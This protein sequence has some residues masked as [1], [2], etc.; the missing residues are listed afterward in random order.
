MFKVTKYPQGAFSWADCSS[1]NANEV[2]K[3]YAD[4]MG[5]NSN[6]LPMGD[7][8][9][10]YMF[11]KDGE[12][13]AGLGQIQPALQEQGI[14]SRWNNYITV[15]DVDAMTARAKE[16]GATVLEEPFD[17]FDSGRMSYVQD[18]T[19][20]G[21]AM[22]QP[23]K[24]IG[25]GLVNTPGAMT[26]NELMTSDTA[27]ATKFYEELFGWTLQKM[28]NVDYYL[29]MNNGRMNGGIVGLKEA[30]GN[31]SSEWITYFSVANIEDAVEKVK[32]NGGKIIND[33]EAAEGIGRFAIISDPHN[34]RC[35]IIQ[36]LQ[37]QAWD[38]N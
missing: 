33:V 16:L 18:P 6:D 5:W 4:L 30:W 29:I 22:W 12:S 26:W 8:Q 24:H 2:K 34:A 11:E 23:N 21:F 36:L 25:S 28:E 38:L 1:T 13:V 3:F 7:G 20:G 31:V 35:A 9:F 17:V 32:A 10:Y 27:K 19:G 15:E 37:P 14:P